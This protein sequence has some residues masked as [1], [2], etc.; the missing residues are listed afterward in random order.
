MMEA[1]SILSLY[2]PFREAAPNRQREMLR[3]V[4]T[5]AL[6]AGSTAFSRGARCGALAL[7]GRG[8]IR[9]VKVDAGGREIT[10]YHVGP[11]ETCLLSLNRAL[12]G[13]TYEAAGVVE[14]DVEAV[15]LPIARFQAW[16][17]EDP[18]FRAFVITAISQR[19]TELM[20]L[21]EEVAFRGLRTRVARFLRSAVAFEDRPCVAIT[22]DEV[23]VEVGATRESVSRIL[24]EFERSGLVDLGRG[25]I[26]VIDGPKL[27]QLCDQ[28][29]PAAA[30]RPCGR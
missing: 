24:K 6:P 18:R 19:V 22:H 12:T 16:F 4:R 9:V 13:G 25:R 15:L 11:G 2:T 10:L 1:R 30:E 3:D 23:G 8:R 28:P 27:V 17:D 7:V 26:C 5:W 29:G 20:E 14:E 21:V